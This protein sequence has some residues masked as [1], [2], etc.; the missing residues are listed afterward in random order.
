MLSQT[1]VF[2]REFLDIVELAKQGNADKLKAK[3]EACKPEKV[4]RF[5]MFTEKFCNS[6]IDE[7]E[8]FEKTNLPKGRPN[9]MNNYGVSGLFKV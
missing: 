7:L 3:I 6:F 9:T 1:S 4:Y 8:N 5:P 2:Q